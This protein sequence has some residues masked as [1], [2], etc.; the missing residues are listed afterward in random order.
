LPWLSDAID[1]Q[2]IALAKLRA[3]LEGEKE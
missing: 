2:T 3:H 1:K